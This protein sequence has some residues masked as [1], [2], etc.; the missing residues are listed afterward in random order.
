MGSILFD[1]QTEVTTD[2]VHRFIH[3]CK[4]YRAMLGGL[5]RPTMSAVHAV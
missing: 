4:M 1:I 2:G 5:G 3:Y